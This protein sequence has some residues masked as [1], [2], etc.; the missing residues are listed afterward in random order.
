MDLK[1]ITYFMWVYEEG[2]FSRAVAKAN[3]VQSALSMQI[4]RIEDEFVFN[5]L[6]RGIRRER[7]ADDLGRPEPD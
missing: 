3:V 5:R 1:Q 4:R 7:S 2:S 6:S